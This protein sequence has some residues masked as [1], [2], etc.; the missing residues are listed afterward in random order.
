MCD[1]LSQSAPMRTARGRWARTGL[2][3]L[4]VGATFAFGA[5]VSVA[6]DGENS[7]PAET[8]AGRAGGEALEE[9]IVTARKRSE[10]LRDIPASIVAIS[11]AV[12]KEAHM[13]QLDDIGSMGSHLHIFAAS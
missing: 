5:T 8:S 1:S 4:T 11:A 6:E 10:N 12:I 2:I 9:I 7:A 13:T 3:T